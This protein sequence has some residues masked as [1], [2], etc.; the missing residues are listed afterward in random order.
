MLLH[1]SF[2][3]RLNVACHLT[4]LFSVTAVKVEC[5]KGQLPTL[6]ST[7]HTASCKN[8]AS[9]ILAFKRRFIFSSL[10]KALYRHPD[11]KLPGGAI[12]GIH[13]GRAYLESGGQ[14]VGEQ[15]QGHG[16]K[17]LHERY[18]DENGE[19]DLDQAATQRLPLHRPMTSGKSAIAR[20][21]LTKRNTSDEVR[22]MS[23]R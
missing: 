22:S 9:S 6:V 12:Q 5:V 16:Q 4:D 19:G 1:F 10:S 2:A 21:I 3:L 7:I 8:R 17:E 20:G 23:L 15:L 18:N 11:S 13:E 14:H